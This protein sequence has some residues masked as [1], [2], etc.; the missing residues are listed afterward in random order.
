[1]R[2]LELIYFQVLTK[3]FENFIKFSYRIIVQVVMKRNVSR[4]INSKY[5]EYVFLTN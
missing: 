2:N 1:M 4:H 3:N 5:F